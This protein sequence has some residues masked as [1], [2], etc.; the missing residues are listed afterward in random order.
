MTCVELVDRLSEKGAVKPIPA[1]DD[2]EDNDDSAAVKLFEL[3]ME[4]L[5]VSEDQSIRMVRDSIRKVW[6]ALGDCMPLEGELLDAVLS[7]VSNEEDPQAGEREDGDAEEDGDNMEVDDED[8]ADEENEE[9]DK[10]EEEEEEEEEV[11]IKSAKGKSAL[12]SV[13]KETDAQKEILVNEDELM[14]LLREGDGDDLEDEDLRAILQHEGTPE[15]DEALASLIELRKTSRKAGL[16][17]AQK[18]E[19]LVRSRAIDILEILLSQR[20]ITSQLLL[21]LISPLMH[22]L[23]VWHSSSMNANIQEAC[24]FELRVRMLLDEKVLIILSLELP[25]PVFALSNVSLVLCCRYARPSRLPR[26]SL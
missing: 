9:D 21:G 8:E 26:I 3:C 1:V 5:S 7:I 12:K 15:Q 19:Y 16:L 17:Q 10:D 13:H 4:Y 25:H 6:T 14:G 20:S 11:P 22:T 23:T 2:G 18:R 24:S